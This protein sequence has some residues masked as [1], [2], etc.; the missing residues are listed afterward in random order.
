MRDATR[1]VTLTVSST[2]SSSCP[3]TARHRHLH[4]TTH[5]GGHNPRGVDMYWVSS[6]PGSLPRT[7]N[8]RRP[9]K[10]LYLAS[11]TCIPSRSLGAICRTS[12]SS[13]HEPCQ[14][15]RVT[16]Q[17]VEKLLGRRGSRGQ[18]VLSCFV[19]NVVIVAPSESVP[20]PAWLLNGFYACL[21]RP[22]MRSTRTEKPRRA[23][24]TDDLPERFCFRV[25]SWR[26]AVRLR[27]GWLACMDNLSLYSAAL[28]PRPQAVF[29]P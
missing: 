21:R 10:A 25:S 15:D 17:G 19:C 14:Y 8:H 26:A 13:D 12:Q 7:P 28:P 27:G 18:T 3:L 5:P 4:P 6:G 1:D 22:L 23:L 20:S 24:H 11:V 29:R 9:I 2:T 16:T